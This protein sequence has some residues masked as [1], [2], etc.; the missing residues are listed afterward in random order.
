ML[1][2]WLGRCY[3]LLR[4][5][6]THKKIKLDCY[7][8]CSPKNDAAAVDAVCSN[9]KE[10]EPSPATLNNSL[11]PCPAVRLSIERNYCCRKI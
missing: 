7:P 8:I 1:A 2:D 5:E 10:T 11:W 6:L 9:K 4:V 3:L